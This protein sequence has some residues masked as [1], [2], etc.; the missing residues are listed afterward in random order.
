MTTANSSSC[1]LV[2][3]E[4]IKKITTDND[5]GGE[6]MDDVCGLDAF[7]W[8]RPRRRFGENH[9]LHTDAHTYMIDHS[10]KFVSRVSVEKGRF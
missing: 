1:G 9:T 10:Y 6:L 3:N 4:R 2:K 7:S 5:M 8:A